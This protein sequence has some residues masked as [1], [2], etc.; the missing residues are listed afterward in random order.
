MSGDVGTPARRRDRTL[1]EA[2]EDAGAQF[3]PAA[4][5]QEVRAAYPRA[6]AAAVTSIVAGFRASAGIGVTHGRADLDAGS[7]LACP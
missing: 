6:S 1:P 3:G 4:M 7:R 5:P 2:E